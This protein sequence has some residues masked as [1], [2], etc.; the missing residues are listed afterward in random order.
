MKRSK[1]K[2]MSEIEADPTVILS[3]ILLRLDRL[4]EI[5][6]ICEEDRMDAKR[7]ARGI[8]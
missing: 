2:P 1:M 3:S 8:K 7:R 4:L 5:I 6:E